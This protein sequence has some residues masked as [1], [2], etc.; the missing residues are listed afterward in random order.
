MSD[1]TG[2]ATGSGGDAEIIAELLE[3]NNWLRRRNNNL[4]SRV[5]DIVNQLAEITKTNVQADPK[6]KA[7]E[8]NPKNYPFHPSLSKIR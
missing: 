5:G 8:T 2:G 4:V 1:Q 7:I 6:D 3:E